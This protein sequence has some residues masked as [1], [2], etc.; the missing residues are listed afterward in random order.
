MVIHTAGLTMPPAAR[1]FV[2]PLFSL[3]L[4]EGRG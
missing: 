4:F 1:V 3:S 2:M